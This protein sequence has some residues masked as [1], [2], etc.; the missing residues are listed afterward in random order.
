MY[1]LLYTID[2]KITD[3]WEYIGE[4]LYIRNLNGSIQIGRK[5]DKNEL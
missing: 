5:R 1:D 2:W 3:K 4:D